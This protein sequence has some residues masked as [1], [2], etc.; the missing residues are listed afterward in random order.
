MN[1]IARSHFRRLYLRAHLRILDSGPGLRRALDVLG[2][3][4][5]L[6][7]VSPVLLVAAVAIKLTSRGPVLFH[8]ERIGRHGH[9]FE[10]LK[11][12]TMVVDAAAQKTA[13]AA[14]SVGATDGV[15]FKLRRDPRVTRVG[16]VLRRFSVD[17][18]PQLW[19][20]IRGEMTLVGPRPP[21]WREVTL[22]DPRSLR[23]LEVTPGLTC[24]WQVGGR[25]DLTFLQ[26]VA[27]DIEYIDCVRPLDELSIVF[28]TV[29]AVLLG[30]GAY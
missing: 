15:R 21:L 17:E 22:Y 2:A 8:Q 18:M 16:A 13:L 9:R 3:S 28:K 12:R 7:F 19:N 25:S 24:L 14:R 11:L 23:R 4:L 27:L 26:Q 6:L 10:L 1:R 5:G 20:V 30:R 29:P